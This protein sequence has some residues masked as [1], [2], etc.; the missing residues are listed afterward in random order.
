MLSAAT[1]S[2]SGCSADT[3]VASLSRA[4]CCRDRA[5]PGG[6]P[7]STVAQAPLRGG[8]GWWVAVLGLLFG[9]R[10]AL[11][12]LHATEEL[13]PCLLGRECHRFSQECRLAPDPGTRV[14]L[15]A[16]SGCP[17]CCGTRAESPVAGQFP[18]SSGGL[19][20]HFGVLPV[21]TEAILGA[22]V[23]QRCV[24]RECPWMWFG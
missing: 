17:S 5:G 16:T 15:L 10:P 11:L 12:S 13:R 4:V 8:S 19:F 20:C 6:P 24:H 9:A 21:E 22:A 7:A 23:R 1:P 3:E 18:E 2:V 14:G